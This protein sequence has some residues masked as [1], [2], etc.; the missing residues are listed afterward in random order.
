M[1]TP[2]SKMPEKVDS[3]FRFVLVAAHRAEQLMQGARVV[4]DSPGD[5][6]STRIAQEEVREDLVAWELGPETEEDE[7]VEAEDTEEGLTEAPAETDDEVH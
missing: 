3:K 4:L 5:K 1:K 6:K 2:T 7:I